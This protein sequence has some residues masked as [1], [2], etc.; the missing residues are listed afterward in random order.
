MKRPSRSLFLRLPLTAW[1]SGLFLTAVLGLACAATAAEPK[2]LLVVTVS[3]GFRHSSIELTEQVIRELAKKSGEFTVIST[4][5]SP[6]YPLPRLPNMGGIAGLSRD[7]QIAVNG[8]SFPPAT[9]NQ[10]LVAARS[11]FATAATGFFDS[12]CVT[13]PAFER[14]EQGQLPV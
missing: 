3:T 13:D 5:E 9:L 10:A 12:I 1:R 2:R 8:L 14:P 6:N 4:S 11:A 7:Q